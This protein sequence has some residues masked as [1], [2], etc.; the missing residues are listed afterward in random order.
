MALMLKRRGKGRSKKLM[1]IMTT[2]SFKAISTVIFQMGWNVMK[3]ESQTKLNV[4]VLS[5][6]LSQSEQFVESCW[7]AE[8]QLEMKDHADK[9][10]FIV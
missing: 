9:N 8:S 2:I 5:E 1:I 6:I 3:T 4:D 7:Y 10:A